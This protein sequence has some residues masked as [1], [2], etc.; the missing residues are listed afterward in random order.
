MK[1]KGKPGYPLLLLIVLGLS[2]TSFIQ[3]SEMVKENKTATLGNTTTEELFL[4][5][6]TCRSDDEC[7]SGV[8]NCIKMDYGI[9]ANWTCTPGSVIQGRYKTSFFCNQSSRWEE[10]KDPGE[11]CSENCECAA[12]TC[13]DAPGCHPGDYLTT[14]INGT[15][16]EKRVID[17][18]EV[19]GLVRIISKEDADAAGDGSCIMTLAQR[20]VMT[21]CAPCGDGTCDTGLETACNCPKDCNPSWIFSIF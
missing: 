1:M 4:P 6:E 14:C 9:C 18:C 19:Q 10:T 3:A 2:C 7:V 17:P 12:R 13:K 5:G 8:C 15:C 21:V 11:S 20:E 16:T